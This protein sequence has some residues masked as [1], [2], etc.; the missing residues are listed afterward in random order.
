MHARFH[1]II[2]LTVAS[3]ATV[4]ASRG[5]GQGARPAA[6]VPRLS[7][8]YAD[9]ARDAL[10]R[11]ELPGHFTVAITRDTGAVE[12]E[13]VAAVFD[14]GGS[15]VY[16]EGAFAAAVDSA[17][18]WDVDGDGTPELVLRRDTGGGNH[19]CPVFTVITL[20]RPARRLLEY[21]WAGAAWFERNDRGAVTLWSWEGGFFGP[22]GTM[23]G[24]IFAQRVYRVSAGTLADATPDHCERIIA[25]SRFPSDPADSARLRVLATSRRAL[26]SLAYLAAD[27]QGRMLQFIFCRRFNEALAVANTWWPATDRR[28]MIPE[29]SEMVTRA[30]PEYAAALHGWR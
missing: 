20:G 5:A 15:V 19:C 22:D 9:R 10:G 7:C 14:S 29:F 23:A 4:A 25:E 6:P 1:S 11:A 3:V 26:D 21:N 16:R 12:T 8:Q 13:C 28:R 18:G 24:R 17:T 30:Y 2:A 27:I